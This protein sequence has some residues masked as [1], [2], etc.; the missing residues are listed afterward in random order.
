MITLKEHILKTAACDSIALVQGESGTGKELI[1]QAIHKCSARA[2]G[3]FIAINC[4]AIPDALL[5]SEL[6]GYEGGAFSG[7]NAQGRK[8]LLEMAHGGTVFFDEISELPYPLQVKLL[9]VLQERSFRRIGGQCL[10]QFDSRVIAA[11]NQNLSDLVQTGKFRKDLYYRLNVVPITAPPLRERR[12][13]IGLLVDYFI[14]AFSTEA[15]GKI[16]GATRQLMRRF[17]GYAWPGNVRELRNFI[18]YG[19]NFC[20]PGLLT[21]EHLAHRFENLLPV[22]GGTE[23]DSGREM[24]E[25]KADVVRLYHARKSV[26]LDQVM[27]AL[28]IHGSTVK[29]KKSAARQLGISLSTLYRI[30][31]AQTEPKP[32]S[33]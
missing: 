23:P 2:R 4:G 1:A 6:F 8:G 7:A 31:R 18:E 3:P 27:R 26:E 24:D 25:R 13:D 21:L 17:E 10:I 20:P 30:L 12:E 32:G 33:C 29:G 19:V 15:S 11:S 9:R 14:K 16:T 5:E 22:A 28:A